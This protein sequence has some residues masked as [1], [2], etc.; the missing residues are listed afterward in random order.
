MI[1]IVVVRRYM[2]VSFLCPE[3]LSPLNVPVEA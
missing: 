1:V 2:T 3:F